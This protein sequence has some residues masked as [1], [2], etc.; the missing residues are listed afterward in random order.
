MGTLSLGVK[1]TQCVTKAQC[2]SLHQHH[3]AGE[4]EPGARP[5][6]PHAVW[7][8]L[9]QVTVWEP[10]G[11]NGLQGWRLRSNSWS[12]ER[13]QAGGRGRKCEAS[14]CIGATVHTL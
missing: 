2:M 9:I 12:N 14:E 5:P 13:A 4:S 6:G 8:T 3:E 7:V 11:G 1:T 10:L